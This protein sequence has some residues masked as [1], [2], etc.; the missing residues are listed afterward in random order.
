MYY[1]NNWYFTFDNK[2]PKHAIDVV[3][4]VYAYTYFDY[5]RSLRNS[6]VAKNQHMPSSPR[7]DKRRLSSQNSHQQ[8][9]QQ[10]QAVPGDNECSAFEVVDCN[11]CDDDVATVA[12]TAA[13][14]VATAATASTVATA[15]TV[16]T[17]ATA[18]TAATAAT[19]SP[20]RWRRRRCVNH[21]LGAQERTL[22]QLVR[23]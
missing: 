12:T 5:Y 11:A 1:S 19:S 9:Q 10:K 23:V 22:Q 16:S 4:A 3:A 14:T 15:A 17:V 2:T 7:S 13:T 18:T 21:D 6:P 8:H 20:L